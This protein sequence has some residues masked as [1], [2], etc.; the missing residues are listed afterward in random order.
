MAAYQAGGFTAGEDAAYELDLW[1]SGRGGAGD[2]GDI[3]LDNTSENSEVVNF[4]WMQ[5]TFDFASGTL[6]E[7][8]NNDSG[9]ILVHMNSFPVFRPRIWVPA[10]LLA[11]PHIVVYWKCCGGQSCGQHWIVRV[12]GVSGDDLK[13]LRTS[14]EADARIE[15]QSTGK[16]LTKRLSEMEVDFRNSRSTQSAICGRKYCR[17]RIVVRV[18]FIGTESTPKGIGG[19]ASDRRQ[20]KPDYPTCAV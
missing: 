3:L 20:S 11:N 12:D 10:S 8:P 17:N 18:P 14:V 2:P 4:T 6:V 19:I 16:L 13:V 7:I 15:V 5:L 1:G 9:D